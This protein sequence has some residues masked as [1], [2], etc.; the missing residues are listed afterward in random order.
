[1]HR[2]RLRDFASHERKHDEHDGRGLSSPHGA[3]SQPGNTR[4]GLESY[5]AFPTDHADAL[6]WKREPLTIPVLALGGEH[7]YG[8]RIVAM[9]KEFAADVSGG[10]IPDCAHWLPEER[11]VET[12]DAVLKFLAG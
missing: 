3:L 4:G 1:M 8:P 6:V 12:A 5:R 7:R 9:L 11:P 2:K 10:S